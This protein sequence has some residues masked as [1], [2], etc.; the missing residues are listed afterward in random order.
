MSCNSINYKQ[1]YDRYINSCFFGAMD[2]C[3][4]QPED[5]SKRAECITTGFAVN[6]DFVDLLKCRAPKYS[7]HYHV[8]DHIRM[9]EEVFS[10]MFIT[11]NKEFNHIL[12][13]FIKEFMLNS[14]WVIYSEEFKEYELRLAAKLAE[15]HS[16]DPLEILEKAAPNSNFRLLRRVAHDKGGYRWDSILT[17]VQDIKIDEFLPVIEESKKTPIRF[18]FNEG[19]MFT[20]LYHIFAQYESQMQTYKALFN[21]LHKVGDI[22]GEDTKSIDA[23]KQ[24]LDSSG[25]FTHTVI[26]QVESTTT[27]ENL[28]LVPLMPQLTESYDNIHALLNDSLGR[29][30]LAGDDS[31]KAERITTGENFRA[32]QPN[33]AFQQAIQHMLDNVTE[34]IQVHFKQSVKFSTSIEPNQQ[35]I[36]I[37]EGQ[38]PKEK[39]FKPNQK[40]KG[41]GMDKG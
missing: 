14:V 35:G 26:A 19:F 39:P 7:F 34:R 27:I 29:L 20:R 16:Q 15:E 9:V 3:F 13:Y 12:K 37:A 32:L 36:P 31:T 11:D 2:W 28:E 33:M 6:K 18:T 23:K 8:F 40:R 22:N 24:Q 4:F 25:V 10:G 38:N 30:G 21:A 41:Y 1:L 17:G 5:Q